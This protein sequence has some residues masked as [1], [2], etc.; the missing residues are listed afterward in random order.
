[1][2]LPI[3]SKTSWSKWHEKLHK[4]LKHK[5]N[6]LPPGSTLLLSISGGQDSMALLKLILDLQRIYEWKIHVWHGDHGW[7]NKSKQICQE[8]KLWCE[9]NQISFVCS[10]TVKQKVSTENQ[11]REWRYQSLINQARSITKENPS[12]ACHYVLTGHTGS[13]KAETFI[14]NL[15]RGSSLGGLSS[16]KECRTLEDKIKLIRPMLNFS[17]EETLKICQELA[18]PIWIDPSNESSKF[19]RNR[20][21]KEILP[22]L[23]NLHPGSTIRIAKLSARLS[24]L[25]NDQNQL[26]KLAIEAIREKQGLNRNKIAS[27]SLS[28]RAIVFAKW[29]QEQKAPVLSSNQLQ[30]LSQKV[31]HTKPPGSINLSENWQIKWDKNLIKLNNDQKLDNG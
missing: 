18:I 10:K 5:S 3:D 20:V 23:E 8:L 16:L 21:R 15:A 22:V 2:P 26:T 30:E 17:R 6:L 13:D 11:A 29:F 4:S 1:M 24:H 31:A 19:T 25:N 14:M 28:A 7:H 12:L 27:L 9:N